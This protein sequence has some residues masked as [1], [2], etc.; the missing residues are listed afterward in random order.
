MLEDTIREVVKG[1]TSLRNMKYP[2]KILSICVEINRLENRGD[3]LY[4]AAIS[5]L[6]KSSMDPLEIIKWKDIY[7]SLENAIDRCEDI[8]NIIEGIVLKNA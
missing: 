6:F 1:V 8:A 7:E 4:R 5:N 3:T 2:E